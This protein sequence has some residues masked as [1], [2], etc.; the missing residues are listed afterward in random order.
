LDVRGHRYHRL[1]GGILQGVDAITNPRSVPHSYPP[2]SPIA[3]RGAHAHLRFASC[4]RKKG[5]S[6]GGSSVQG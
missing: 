1:H 3:A 5:W 2:S 4:H 6:R